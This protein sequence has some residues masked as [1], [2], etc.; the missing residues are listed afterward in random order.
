MLCSTNVMP[1]FS[2]VSMTALSFWLPV[3]AAMYE[4]PERLARK[5]LSMNGNYPKLAK[6]TPQTIV[7]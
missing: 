2:A 5:T 6:S 3:G 1:S 4:T 7:Q